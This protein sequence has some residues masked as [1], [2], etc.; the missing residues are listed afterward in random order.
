MTETAQAARPPAERG[1]R[2]RPAGAP[3]QQAGPRFIPALPTLRPAHLLPTL[4]R[5]AP[6][7]FPLGEP[8]GRVRRSYLARGAIA[9]GLAALGL[10]PDAVALMPGYHHGVEVEAVRAAGLSVRFYDV[11]P[12]LTIDLDTLRA[13]LDRRVRVVYATHFA[14]FPAPVAAL[15]ALCDERDLVLLEDCALALLSRAPDGQPL[16]TTGDLAVFCLYKTVPVPHGGLLIARHLP[17]E[18]A[19]SPRLAATLSHVCGSLLRSLEA[20]SP[21]IGAA[22]REGLR[23]AFRLVPAEVRAPVG[24]QHL[25][26]AELSLGASRLLDHILPHLAYR[27]IVARRRRNYRRLATLVDAPVPT[28]PLPSG[29]CPLFVPVRVA[30][31]DTVLA[32]LWR[33][34]IEAVDLW[35]EGLEP[36]GELPG[37]AELR[38]HVIELPCHQDLDDQD[39]DRVAAV[40]REARGP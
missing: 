27:D 22:V 23:R 11:A 9:S 34:G 28:G 39:I 2:V 40:F 18:P 33:R 29:T 32:H 7:P 6:L 19:R 14:G 5:A 30:A 1:P 16:G 37:A 35:R 26:P 24:R 10:P 12:D 8:P 36:A 21:E 3:A 20:A 13:R 15:R 4:G 17:P 25:D 38:R 31:R